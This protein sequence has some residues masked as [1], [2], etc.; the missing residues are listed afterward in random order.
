MNLDKLDLAFRQKTEIEVVR[1]LTCNFDLGALSLAE[2]HMSDRLVTLLRNAIKF[3]THLSM[4]PTTLDDFSNK[5]KTL[6]DN[7]EAVYTGSAS[8]L[9]GYAGKL[10]TEAK[11][12]LGTVDELVSFNEFSYVVKLYPWWMRP[13]NKAFGPYID[14][15]VDKKGFFCTP[16]FDVYSLGEK[17]DVAF[18]SEEQILL[19]NK[20]SLPIIRVD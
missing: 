8:K 15:Y 5:I 7:A 14:Q 16:D 17:E 4:D 18:V 2:P 12:M 10:L 3:R 13:V 20:L 11:T 19:K 6:C 9:C 1:L